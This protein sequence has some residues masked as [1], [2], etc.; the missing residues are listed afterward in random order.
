[1]SPPRIPRNLR[2]RK[3]TPGGL[4]V[5]SVLYFRLDLFAEKV[6]VEKGSVESTHKVQTSHYST[7]RNTATQR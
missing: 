4:L 2:Y 6:L 5:W 1:M 7:T 3:K